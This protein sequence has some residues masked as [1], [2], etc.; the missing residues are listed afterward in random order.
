MANETSNFHDLGLSAG[1]MERIADAG[2][3]SPTEVQ[4]KA[5]P[6]ILMGRD[7][8]ALAST[9]SGKTAAFCL[10]ILDILKQSTQR[11]RMPR[12]VILE[13][14]RELA[15]QVATVFEAFATQD[16]K[17]ALLIGGTPM[18]PQE[19]MLTQGPD[20]IIA[21]PGRLLDHC[22]RGNVL[23]TQ[24]GLFVIDEADRMLD[25]G[26]I[27]S[28]EQ[29]ARTIPAGRRQTMML[30][31]TMPSEIRR[32]AQAFLNNPRELQVDATVQTATG[33]DDFLVLVDK[34]N[35]PGV[36]RRV[37]AHPELK[38]AIVFSNRKRDISTI[39]RMLKRYNFEAGSLHGDMDQKQRLAELQAFT[40][41]KVKIIICS[42]VAA[43]GLDIPAVSHVINYDAPLQAEDYVHR[44][45]RT[46]R[47]GLK[48]TAFMLQVPEEEKQVQAVEKLLGR[49]L[50][51]ADARSLEAIGGP[52]SASASSGSRT[53]RASRPART[54]S[55]DDDDRDG[56]RRDRQDGASGGY[57]RDTRRDT[58]P[59][60]RPDDGPNRNRKRRSR[61][62]VG[63][64][65][66]AGDIDYD[67]D[68]LPED[69]AREAARRWEQE[70][71]NSHNGGDGGDG[72]EDDSSTSR[73]RRNRTLRRDARH[74]NRSN[75]RDPSERAQ[76]Y[77]D[78]GSDQDA[79]RGSDYDPR[80]IQ[81]AYQSD[82]GENSGQDTGGQEDNRGRRR[83]SSASGEIR[84]R[85]RGSGRRSGRD[86][87]RTTADG[88]D[89]DRSSPRRQIQPHDIAGL[90]E[91]NPRDW[92]AFLLR[93]P[94]GR[95]H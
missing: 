88:S 86:S 61:R 49:K 19:R 18:G 23:L 80:A 1:L 65:E 41:G 30:S 91:A 57:S 20:I 60:S 51:R 39:V 69:E 94:V 58:T 64:E 16:Y 93:P 37:L 52:G 26:F 35:K 67:P 50:I 44:V 31:A 54:S 9:G 4:R 95:R 38:N 42:D 71:P 25:M 82:D 45:G 36:L 73:P 47:A 3:Q 28:I 48:G 63:Q 76:P 56:N 40:D 32:L 24:V 81:G 33:I 46:G 77:A 6:Q 87:E 84:G 78:S 14:T 85:S 92:P 27:P 8:I 53:S 68:A 79:D 21:T 75:R 2:F 15:A 17:I 11:A 5:I 83:S 66:P 62:S 70:R 22:E 89:S 55:Y 72:Y 7:V 34:R 43:R 10:P 90:A 59:D 29:I 13:P 74:G 12:A